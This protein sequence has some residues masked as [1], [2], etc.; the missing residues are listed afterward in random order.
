M[1]KPRSSVCFI[2]VKAFF[3]SAWMESSCQA[4]WT[5]S[6]SSSQQPGSTLANFPAAH[7]GPILCPSRK[8]Y[9]IWTRLAGK[10]LCRQKSG[11]GRMQSC[12]TLWP[13]FRAKRG[14]FC[15]IRCLIKVHRSWRVLQTNST[16]YFHPSRFFGGGGQPTGLTEPTQLGTSSKSIDF[17]NSGVFLNL[18]T[19][20]AQD[21]WSP[22]DVTKLPF[23][24][25]GSIRKLKNSF[26]SFLV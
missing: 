16:L 23:K 18:F 2:S 5:S 6:S 4:T 8:R 25:R 9:W 26:H 24:W 14:I 10:P 7:A 20:W 17:W 15:A 3:P 13:S 19:A 22:F 21:G 11:H 12:S 1:A